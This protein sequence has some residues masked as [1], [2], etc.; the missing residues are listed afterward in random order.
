M[1]FKFLPRADQVNTMPADALVPSDYKPAVSM[2]F[3][4]MDRNMYFGWWKFIDTQ[5]DNIS[6]M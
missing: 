3:S 5:E 6:H 1:R 4:C 2:L